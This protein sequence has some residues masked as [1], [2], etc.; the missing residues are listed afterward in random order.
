MYDSIVYRNDKILG[1]VAICVRVRLRV[2]CDDNELLVKTAAK[3]SVRRYRQVL[4]SG[5]SFTGEKRVHQQPQK[6]ELARQSF[7]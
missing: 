2:S 3:R 5:D 6:S 7:P 1:F 4:P